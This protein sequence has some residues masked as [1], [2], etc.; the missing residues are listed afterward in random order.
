MLMPIPVLLC[1]EAD[2]L[3]GSAT[4]TALKKKLMSRPPMTTPAEDGTPA[5]AA[6]TPQESAPACAAHA[7]EDGAPKAAAKAPFSALAFT[8][9]MTFFGNEPLPFYSIASSELTSSVEPGDADFSPQAL[10][11]ARNTSASSADPGSSGGGGLVGKG[12]TVEEKKLGHLKDAAT[13]SALSAKAASDM[14]QTQKRRLML[15]AAQMSI[16][17]M[18]DY[19]TVLET[20][21]AAA[22]D[23]LAQ[24]LVPSDEEEE[25]RNQVTQ[26]RRDLR[27]AKKQRR[28]HLQAT[29]QSASDIRASAAAELMPS[30]GTFEPGAAPAAAV[31]LAAMS[32]PV[33]VFPRRMSTE[34]GLVSDLGLR[35]V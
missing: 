10:L 25:C 18:N 15:D 7:P 34:A 17:A 19:V 2:E 14:A 35:S 5:N 27:E 28:E 26:M 11:L 30:P 21:I 4:R 6:D 9:A 1:S 16:G 8:F 3:G 31:P 32:S 20:D 24:G 22:N 13:N 29:A 12:A 23:E 33:A